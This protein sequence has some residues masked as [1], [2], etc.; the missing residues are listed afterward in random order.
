L[1][2]WWASAKARSGQPATND[3]TIARAWKSNARVLL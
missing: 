2:N 1:T 3:A